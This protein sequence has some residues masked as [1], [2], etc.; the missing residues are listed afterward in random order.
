MSK[1]RGIVFEQEAPFVSPDKCY[2]KSRYGHVCTDTAI[3]YTRLPNGLY[4]PTFDGATSFITGG[5]GESLNVGTKDFSLVGWFNCDS[6]LAGYA[7]I[8][9]KGTLGGQAYALY[10]RNDTEQLNFRTDDTTEATINTAAQDYTDDTWH[11]FVVTRAG[12]AGEIIVDGVSQ[13]TGVVKAT[14]LDNTQD[15]RIGA[16]SG[17]TSWPWLGMVALLRLYKYQMTVGKA[18]QLFEAERRLFGV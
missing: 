6:A 7:M 1:T 13:I 5:T 11:M 8:M 10:V 16:R 15:F 4:V 12:A 14:D 2:D 17:G 3:T 9:T 18:L